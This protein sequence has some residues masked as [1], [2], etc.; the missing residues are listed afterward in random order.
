M[1][2][3]FW[4]GSDNGGDAAPIT[5]L[6]FDSQEF[7]LGDNG[8]KKRGCAC[9]CVRDVNTQTPGHLKNKTLIFYPNPAK[10]KIILANFDADDLDVT[11]FSITGEIL[12]H[13]RLNS[14]PTEINIQSLPK[15]IYIIEIK[16]LERSVRQQLLKE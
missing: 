11:I 3:Q 4:S 1:Y 7:V 13:N 8:N 5:L 2:A 16:C 14:S 6:S 10:D 15:G 9:R 12:L